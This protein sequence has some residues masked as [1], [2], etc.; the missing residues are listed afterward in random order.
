[1]NIHSQLCSER[2]GLDRRRRRLAW[3][4]CPRRIGY[5]SHRDSQLITLLPE[6]MREIAGAP[7]DRSATE[8]TRH[9]PHRTT[10]TALVGVVLDRHHHSPPDAWLC[11][12]GTFPR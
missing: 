12:A 5:M 4:S 8:R 1:M 11:G 9:R 3:V 10:T 2:L 7:T 6:V